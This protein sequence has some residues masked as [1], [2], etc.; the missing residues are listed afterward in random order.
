MPVPISIDALS[1]NAAENYPVGTEP[2]FPNLD[3]YLRAHAAFIAQLRDRLDSEG[4]P[5]AAVM[6]WGGA[7]SVISARFKPLDGQILVR[8]DFPALWTFISGGG[9]PMVSDAEWTSAPLKRASF[10][11]GDG[12]TTFRMPDL[13]GVQANSIGAATVRGDGARSAGPRL[14]LMK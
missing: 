5:L 9:Y 8:A 14:R 3:N 10:S 4:L 7:R 12:A 11:S 6:W 1:P 13:N 2:V